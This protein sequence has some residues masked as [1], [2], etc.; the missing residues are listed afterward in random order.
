MLR[1]QLG[2]K[3]KLRIVITAAL[4]GFTVLSA[5][6]FNAL[7]VL[8]G[9]SQRVDNINHNVNLLKDLHLNVLHLSAQPSVE[10]LEQLLPQYGPQL[11]LLSLE[12]LSQQ[13]ETIKATH[14]S[15]E[16]WVKYR[17]HWLIERQRIGL[18]IDQGIRV[19]VSEKATELL[20]MTERFH[21]LPGDRMTS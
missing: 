17:L 9:A 6:S 1:Y 12:L 11:N 10:E 8:G 2:F 18:D 4:I 19:E 21:F 15:L 13:A 7:Q 14:Q 5:I 20:A 3:S 16:Y